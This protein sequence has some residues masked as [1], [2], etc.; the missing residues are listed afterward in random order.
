MSC[1]L[2]TTKAATQFLASSSLTFNSACPEKTLINPSRW[3]LKS[4][5]STL[6][7]ARL[8]LIWADSRERKDH[9][10]MQVQGKAGTCSDPSREVSLQRARSTILKIGRTHP[11]LTHTMGS[12]G[13]S[14]S[15]SRTTAT[16]TQI[17]DP[18]SSRIREKCWAERRFRT[19]RQTTCS[20][21]T[22]KLC[23]TPST[24]SKVWLSKI[25][26]DASN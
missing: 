1:H 18:M 19:P 8:L 22:T 23:S 17:L 9:K 15:W 24:K 16:T 25:S 11:I 7:P 14:L 20:K 21:C 10:S 12:R 26:S 13:S 5:K 6:K 2:S 4:Q 3:H